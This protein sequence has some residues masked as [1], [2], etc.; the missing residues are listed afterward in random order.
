MTARTR[1][2]DS[3]AIM[4]FLENE[5]AAEKVE[6]ILIEA[7]NSDSRLLISVVNLGEVWYSVARAQSEPAADQLVEQVLSL[8]VEAVP[9]DWAIG[10]EAARLKIRGRI[11]YADCF[12][13]GLAIVENCELVTGDQEFRQFED[14]IQIA[15]V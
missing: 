10:R 5:P 13:A 1:V 4:A 15:W 9:V 3:W 12:A 6:Q 11:A 14:L 8:G 7:L 2:L